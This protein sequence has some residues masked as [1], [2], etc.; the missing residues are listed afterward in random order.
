VFR[1]I[2]DR[3][4]AHIHA[5]Y[6]GNIS[7]KEA[8]VSR[9]AELAGRDDLSQAIDAVKR[10]QSEWKAVGMTPVAAD[11]KLWKAFRGSCDAVFARLDQ[12]RAAQ[13]SESEGQVRQAEALRDQARELLRDPQPEGL[14]QL[15]KAIAELKSAMQAISLPPPVQQRLGKDF[16]AMEAEG[17]ELA[18]KAR[19][20]REQATWNHLESA[21]KV[22]ASLAAG[23]ES[24]AAPAEDLPKGIDGKLVAA[25]L[26][27]GADAS[28]DARSREAC[29]ALEVFGEI[30]SP[31]EDKAARMSYQLNRLAAGMGNRVVDPQQALLSQVNAFIALRPSLAFVQRFC[32]G[33]DR[34]RR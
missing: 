10:L 18:G 33:L 22:A 20:Q 23:E 25:F 32:A 3:I 27:Q 26:H 28:A 30:E 19:K 24:A 1:E 12:Q 15:A 16:Q 31:P 2:C 21:L 7:L 11:R 4:Y 9:A 17:R 34:I 29:I 14:P 8:L 5:E 6:Q 13:K